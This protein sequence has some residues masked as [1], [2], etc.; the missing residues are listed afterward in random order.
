MK[1]INLKN[2]KN[3]IIKQIV[4]ILYAIFL[5]V[6]ILIPLMSMHESL[7]INIVA[8]IGLVIV[9]F[10]INKQ[11]FKIYYR[12]Q[13]FLIS[14]A[15]KYDKFKENFGYIS[16]L[17]PTIIL[18]IGSFILFLISNYY[19]YLDINTL[20]LEIDYIKITS[21]YYSKFYSIS[22]IL[23][24]IILFFSEVFRLTH[25]KVSFFKSIISSIF[26]LLWMFFSSF[27]VIIIIMKILM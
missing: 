11:I 21:N 8:F 4:L 2:R 27:V 12:V 9:L 17:V 10:Y 23:S 20:S 16:L 25:K 22:I 14:K 5:S 24:A 18:G 7:I 26:G 1:K 3:N 15:F 6:V 19:L 13:A